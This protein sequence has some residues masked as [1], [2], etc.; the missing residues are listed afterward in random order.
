LTRELTNYL[1]AIRSCANSVERKG[2][3]EVFRSH[4]SEGGSPDAEAGVHKRKQLF[5]SALQTITP[6][7]RWLSRAGNAGFFLREDARTGQLERPPTISRED[8]IFS[9][10]NI[11]VNLTKPKAA[12]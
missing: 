3:T 10:E 2:D 9:V 6:Q 1:D 4:Q 5:P 8:R 11:R 7:P 12:N